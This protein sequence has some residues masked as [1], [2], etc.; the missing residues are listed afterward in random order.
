MSLKCHALIDFSKAGLD[1]DRDEM[2][3]FLLNIAEELQSGGLVTEAYLTRESDTPDAAKS[4][5]TAFLMGILTAEINRENIRKVINFLGNQFYG[6]S[7]TLSGEI[8]ENRMAF[9]FECQSQEDIDRAIDAF[10]RMSNLHFERMERMSNL[11]IKLIE[12]QKSAD[13]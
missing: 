2:E 7:L 5:T 3:V 8:D 1:F 13:L 9:N 11:H 6:K 4:G 12:K 10:E